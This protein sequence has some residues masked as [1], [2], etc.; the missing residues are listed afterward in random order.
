M[1]DNISINWNKIL[2]L[3]EVRDATGKVDLD[4][5]MNLLRE[6][7]EEFLEQEISQEQMLD[8]INSV[9]D[10]LKETDPTKKSMKIDVLVNRS[11][12]ILKLPIE[13]DLTQVQK[14]F[15]DFINAE[16]D[17]FEESLGDEGLFLVKRGPGMGAFRS[18]PE[19]TSAYKKAHDK[20]QKKQG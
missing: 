5:A 7:A 2:A 20:N 15:K 10:L 9:F 13:R 6:D 14:Q 11:V 12:E 4:I 8:A 18:E 19:L 1:I 16:S 3:P 17:K